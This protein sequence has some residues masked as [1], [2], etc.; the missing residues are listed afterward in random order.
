MKI[1]NGFISNSSSS[2]FIVEL[3]KPIENYSLEEFLTDYE[4]E[5]EIKHCGIKLFNDLKKQSKKIE[6]VL[7]AN[8][9]DLWQEI[10][11]DIL[12]E[13]ILDYETLFDIREEAYNYIIKRIKEEL[14][15][16]YNISDDIFTTYEVE[17]GDNFMETDFMPCFKGTVK[18]ISHH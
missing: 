3:E 11:V 10:K 16:K 8:I 14:I 17:Y 12:L 5:D 2:S 13:N 6:S 7:K 4:I 18:Q 15:Q 9:D 1:R